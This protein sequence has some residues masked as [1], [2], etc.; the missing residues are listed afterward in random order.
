LQSGTV[1][2]ADFIES[3]GIL[4]NGINLSYKAGDYI[5]LPSNFEVKQGAEFE[6]VIDGCMN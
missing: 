1:K 5:N 3:N 2:V 6:A 4:N